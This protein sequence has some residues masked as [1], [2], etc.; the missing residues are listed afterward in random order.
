MQKF[1]LVSPVIPTTVKST[2]LGM[3]IFVVSFVYCYL[4]ELYLLYFF[5]YKYDSVNN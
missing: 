4:L 1:Y 3:L 2:H 5:L